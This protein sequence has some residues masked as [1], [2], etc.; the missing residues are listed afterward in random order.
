LKNLQP[1][2]SDLQQVEEDFQLM[3]R[4]VDVGLRVFCFYKALKMNDALGKIVESWSAI[5]PDYDSCNINADHRDMTKFPG[6][7]DAGYGQIYEV[8]SR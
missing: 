5:L 4:R 7:A 2:S 8:L 3:L 6:R 1:G